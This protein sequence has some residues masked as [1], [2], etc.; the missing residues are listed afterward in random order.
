MAPECRGKG[1]A[2]QMMARMAAEA[3]TQGFEH[4][5]FLC[6]RRAPTHPLKPVD[7]QGPDSVWERL[8][9]RKLGIETSFKWR[10]FGAGGESFE[11]EH[12]ME[13]WGK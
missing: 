2:G 7:Y 3:K 5:C 9:Y 12:V 10:A 6:V 13:Y 1:L 4:T 8:G 11:Q